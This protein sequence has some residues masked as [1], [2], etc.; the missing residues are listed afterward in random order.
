MYVNE[1]AD[2]L[3]CMIVFGEDATT[4]VYVTQDGGATW[5]EETDEE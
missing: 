5:E 3:N 1:M 2:A 4:L